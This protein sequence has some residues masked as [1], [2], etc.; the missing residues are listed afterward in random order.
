M[1]ERCMGEGS[2]ERVRRVGARASV[3]L[4]AVVFLAAALAP[5]RAEPLTY[6]QVL[7]RAV[8]HDAALAIARLELERARLETAR[9]ESSLGWVASG[10]AGVAHDLN[11]FG[12]PADRL[13]AGANLERRLASGGSVGVGVAATHDEAD[14]TVLPL[15]PNP[16]QSVG[17]DARYRL[18][19]KQGASNVDYHQGLA[20]AQAGVEAAQASFQAARDQL[21]Q[22]VAELFYAA[23]LTYARLRNAGEAIERAERLKAFVLRNVRLGVAEEKDRLQA[24][25]Q[26]RARLAEQQA[27]AAA[28]DNQRITL[29]RLMERGWESDWQ[30]RVEEQSAAVAFDLAALQAEAVANSPELLRDQASLRVAEATIARRRDAGRDKVDLVFSVGNRRLSGDQAI[31]RVSESETVAGVRLEYRATLDRRGADAELTQAYLERDVARRRYDANLATVRY[32]VARLVAEIEALSAALAQA[33][34]RKAAE[35]EKLEE[36][37]RR[38]GTGRANT[39]EVIQFENDYEAAALAAEQQAIELARRRRELERLRGTLWSG[40][41]FAPAAAEAKP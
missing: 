22:Q 33:R 37:T 16:A 35:R 12:I 25:A 11:T 28:W 10:Q 18:P 36:A 6:A 14:A 7:Q 15:L 27:L 2:L 5:A 3:G 17:I 19:L 4:I 41:A 26:L 34:E 13:E 21:A 24:E 39:A 8:A 29:N 40:I 23:A 9:I 20:A 31:G 1:N 38:H 30:P 32:S